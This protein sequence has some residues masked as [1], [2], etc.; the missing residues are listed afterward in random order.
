MPRLGCFCGGGVLMPSFVHGQS[1]GLCG[2]FLF[3]VH[4]PAL[5]SFLWF[6]LYHRAQLWC[7]ALCAAESGCIPVVLVFTWYGGH[8]PVFFRNC[9]AGRRPWT[10]PCY[11][12]QCCQGLVDEVWSRGDMRCPGFVLSLWECSWI[13]CGIY[14]GRVS[15]KASEKLRKVKRAACAGA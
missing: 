9:R 14:S 11:V 1:G 12:E 2:Q 10:T 3:S 13:L 8:S 4:S 6:P 15:R 7:N 5:F